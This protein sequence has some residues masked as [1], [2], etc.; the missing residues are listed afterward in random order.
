MDVH[1]IRRYV[2]DGRTLGEVAELAGVSR[3]TARRWLRELGLQTARMR[4]LR[5]N[6]AAR[7]GEETEVE[8]SCPRHGLSSHVRDREGAFRCR[9]C[10]SADVA[11]RRS[12]VRDVLIGEAGGA[13]ALC[14]YAR[15]AGALHF[16][17]VRPEEKSFTIRNGD[18]RALGLMRAE[19]RK[20]VLL[21]ANCHAE[22]EAGET[23]LPALAY[24]AASVATATDA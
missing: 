5:E 23:A 2:E 19:A 9:R 13:C 8:R 15:Y 24:H 21:C 3:D 16:H 20:C 7:A 12:R 4:A 22:V 10:R 14:G 1:R 11:R 17:H 6:A 18:T